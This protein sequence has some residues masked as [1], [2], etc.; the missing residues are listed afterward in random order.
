MLIM[1]QFANVTA[2]HGMLYQTSQR[3]VTTE[4]LGAAIFFSPVLCG[5]VVG[6]ACVD[7]SS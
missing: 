2:S 4:A 1:A 6:N 5:D 7:Q 3:L